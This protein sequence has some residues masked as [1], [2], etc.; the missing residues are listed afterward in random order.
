[1]IYTCDNHHEDWKSDNLMG[2]HEAPRGGK[3]VKE[4]GLRLPEG[5][6]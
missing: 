5:R 2:V 4:K 6:K 1:V 3:I